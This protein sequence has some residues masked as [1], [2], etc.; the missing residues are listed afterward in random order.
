MFSDSVIFFKFSLKN[1]PLQG[2]RSSLM[3]YGLFKLNLDATA[4]T[5]HSTAFI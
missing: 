2:G 3:Q 5:N 1:V 4:R